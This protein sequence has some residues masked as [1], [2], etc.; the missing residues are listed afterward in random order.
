MND[1]VEVKDK[2]F[3]AGYAMKFHYQGARRRRIFS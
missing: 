1:E 3:I 2:F